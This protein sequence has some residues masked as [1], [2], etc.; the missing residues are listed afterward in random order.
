[1]KK[2]DDSM[3]DLAY[4]S[5]FIGK[6]Y[7]YADL[8]R[9][10]DDNRYEIIN[11]NLYLM[12]APTV[13][14]QM[15]AGAIHAQLYNFLLGKT[16]KVFIPPIDVALSK[17]KEDNKIKNIVQPDVLVVC[18]PN[19]IEKKK[20]F[21][22]PDFIVEVLSN[23]RRHDM[24]YKFNLYQNWG[25]K[26]YWMIDPEEGIIMPY[27]LNENGF[28]ER[29]KFYDFREEIPVKV[30]D[31]CKI[32]LKQLYEDNKELFE[33]IPENYDPNEIDKIFGKYIDD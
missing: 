6:E 4:K 7:T 26:E 29:T 27:I 2:E 19:K 16:C 22:A 9:I 13:T 33:K 28:Y 14:H 15:I 12:S 18:D 23:D 11:G 21:G 30:L 1:M 25:V 20:I 24:L 5:D 10:D 17:N 32:C 8:Q 3:E 31:G